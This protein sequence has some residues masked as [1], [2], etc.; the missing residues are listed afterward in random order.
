MIELVDQRRL[1][2]DV[3]HEDGSHW[4]EVRELPGCFVSGRSAAEVIESAEEAVVLYLTGKGAP[5]GLVGVELA[6]FDL[7]IETDNSVKPS[8]DVSTTER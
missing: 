4:A 5:E 8:E 6:G 2:V 1:R 3:H 7:R